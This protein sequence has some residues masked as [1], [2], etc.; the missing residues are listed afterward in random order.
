MKKTTRVRRQAFGQVMG[1]SAITL[2]TLSNLH[3]QGTVDFEDRVSGEPILTDKEKQELA[4]LSRQMNTVSN[5]IL[6]FS[7]KLKG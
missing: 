2:Q 7:H 5:N 3:F 4:T 1:S 6:R